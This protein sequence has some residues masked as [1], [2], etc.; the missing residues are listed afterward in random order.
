MKPNV[1]KR[2][3]LQHG[4]WEDER[5]GRQVCSRSEESCEKQ[6]N[7]KPNIYA[8]CRRNKDDEIDYHL[9]NQ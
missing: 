3:W 4:H 5:K 7:D 8:D 1:A 9:G 2:I 6:T